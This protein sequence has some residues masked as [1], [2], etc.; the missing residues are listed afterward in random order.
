MFGLVD[1][2]EGV[3]VG[4]FESRDRMLLKAGEDGIR[5][6]N[7]SLL[8][9]FDLETLEET[10]MAYMGEEEIVSFADGSRYV[11]AS[12]GNGYSFL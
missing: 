11:L 7:G 5:L 3:Y 12:V 1:T 9:R 4:E 6:A 2:E 10:E 8:V